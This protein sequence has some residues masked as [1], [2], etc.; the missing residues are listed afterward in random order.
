MLVC[1]ASVAYGRVA[2]QPEEAVPAQPASAFLR[3]ERHTGSNFLEEILS[4]NFQRTAEL[5]PGSMMANATCRHQRLSVSA[6][7]YVPTTFFSGCSTHSDRAQARRLTLPHQLC[8]C[9]AATHTL[10]TL[11]QANSDFCCWK[12]GVACS[13][14]AYAPPV[15]AMVALVR[16]PYPFLLALHKDPYESDY[17]AKQMSF[18][19]FLRSPWSSRPPYYSKYE[20]AANPVEL[21]VQKMRSY[22]KYPGEKVVVRTSDL[23]LI[24]VLEQKL[25]KLD[26]LG[27]KR[28]LGKELQYPEFTESSDESKWEGKFSRSGFIHAALAT[29]QSSWLG[30]YNQADLDFVNSELK[31]LGGFELLSWAGINRVDVASPSADTKAGEHERAV[32]K[33]PALK[34]AVSVFDMGSSSPRAPDAAEGKAAVRKLFREALEVY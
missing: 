3:A 28:A 17:G 21:W 32:G 13:A 1:L 2:L 11:P 34:D 26:Q 23:F 5:A 7:C 15:T 33:R 4:L 14:D 18:S 6:D 9:T 30:E 29:K 20:H 25:A 27:F 12:H 16:S 10:H 31:R 24:D 19:E 8:T 22:Q